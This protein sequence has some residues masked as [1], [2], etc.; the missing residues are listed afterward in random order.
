[1]TI[2][3]IYSRII[4]RME[5]VEMTELAV[6]DAAGKREAVRNIR[7]R[8][9]AGKSAGVNVSTIEAIAPVLKTSVSW[10]LRAEGPEEIDL[11]NGGTIPLVG[12]VGAGA[13]AQLYSEGQGPFD[14]VEAP[15]GS[16]EKTVA[17]QIKGESLGRAFNSWLV[18]YD[19]IRGPPT[20][21][22]L[23][24]LCVVGLA[25]GRVLV[26]ILE[27]G[28]IPKTFNLYPN[29]EGGVIYDAVVEWAAKVK[30]AM[31]HF[32]YPVRHVALADAGVLR[33][34][35][36]LR[37]LSYD[38]FEGSIKSLRINVGIRA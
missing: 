24:K 10:L 20:D 12:F 27:K 15:E 25:D 32:A 4:R 11:E 30:T 18:F 35:L 26:K 8:I 13:E 14:Y 36:L 38:P 2:K 6:G 29:T 37:P 7:R 9:E 21:D 23:S 17:V 31:L 33:S 19:D 1:M 22:L 34:G 3:D 16:T 28:G 5:A